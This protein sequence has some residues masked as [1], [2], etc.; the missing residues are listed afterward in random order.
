L[1]AVG[2]TLILYSSN[3]KITDIYISSRGVEFYRK[4]KKKTVFISWSKILFI[5]YREYYL[6]DKRIGY[7]GHFFK[8]IIEYHEN[9]R[10]KRVKQELDSVA[11]QAEIQ[12]EIIDKIAQRAG[13]EAIKM[14]TIEGSMIVRRTKKE[15]N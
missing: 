1:G 14:K 4:A 12:K 11:E 5:K 7:R 6:T 3:N 2:L 8:L 15:K 13:K 10:K 9:T